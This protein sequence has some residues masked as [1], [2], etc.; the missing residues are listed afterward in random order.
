MRTASAP[1]TLDILA[2][3]SHAN[4][5]SVLVNNADSSTRKARALGA[6]QAWEAR[7]S[8]TTASC[9]A[10]SADSIEAAASAAFMSCLTSQCCPDMDKSLPF[11]RANA[12]QTNRINTILGNPRG[13]WRNSIAF[14]H[15]ADCS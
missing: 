15:R 10:D 9:T 11:N 2:K 5:L 7:Y 13:H 8:R 1:S 6:F 12:L 4:D 14:W 3:V